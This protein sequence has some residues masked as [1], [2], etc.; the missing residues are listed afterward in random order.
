[1]RYL[2]LLLVCLSGPVWAS[3]TPEQTLEKYFRILTERDYSGISSLM[4]SASMAG[5]KKTMDDAMGIQSSRGVNTL[6]LRIFGKAVSTEEID[7]TPASFYLESLAAEILKASRRQQLI[8]SQRVILGRVD[9]GEDRT[10]IVA[11]LT[12]EQGQHIGNEV[13]VYTLVRENNEWKLRFPA[14]I[15]QMVMM[16]EGAARQQ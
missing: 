5:L 9:E 13:L 6:Q 8:V 7:S 4:D 12:M 15:K 1:M 2:L 10:H 3:T 14:T 16:I 11:R